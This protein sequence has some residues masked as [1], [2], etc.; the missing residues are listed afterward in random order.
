MSRSRTSPASPDAL[1]SSPSHLSSRSPSLWRAGT[2]Q[3]IRE[4]L[5][6]QCRVKDGEGEREGEREETGWAKFKPRKTDQKEERET[7]LDEIDV[8]DIRAIEEDSD[9]SIDVVGDGEEWM[10]DR[11]EKQTELHNPPIQIREWKVPV[12]MHSGIVKPPV[13][14]PSHSIREVDIDGS[15]GS[16][17]EEEVDVLGGFSPSPVHPVML[18]GSWGGLVLRK[19]RSMSL[20]SWTTPLLLDICHLCSD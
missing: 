5:Q 12:Q 1:R 15:T 19:K 16:W 8:E 13:S 6:T 10:T 2:P 18:P 3:K 9:G 14:H 7:R 11:A 17:E 20:E 4:V